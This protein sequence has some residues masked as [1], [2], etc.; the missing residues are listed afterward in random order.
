LPSTTVLARPDQVNL[1]LYAGD[2]FYLDLTVVN[3]D[4]TASDLSGLTATAEVRATTDDPVIA[5]FTATMAA[6]VVSL[7]LAA[8]DVA[9]L[10]AAAVWDCQLQG[11]STWTVAAGT[12]RT[13]AQVTT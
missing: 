6:N 1:C 13:A 9:A 3:P 12:V 2:D 4:G 10:P 11:A 5:T 7:W 8:A